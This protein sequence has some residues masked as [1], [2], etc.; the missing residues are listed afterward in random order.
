MPFAAR[1]DAAGPDDGEAYSR[2]LHGDGPEP[3]WPACPRGFDP[4]AWESRRQLS[5]GMGLRLRG[6]LQAG[7]HPPGMPRADCQALDDYESALRMVAEAYV[8]QFGGAA[9]VGEG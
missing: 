1:P 4:L 7:G 3:P 2:W 6:D 5:R 9:D 8:A